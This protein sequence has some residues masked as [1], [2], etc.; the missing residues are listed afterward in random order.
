MN[1][2]QSKLEDRTL[3]ACFAGDHKYQLRLVRADGRKHLNLVRWTMYLICIPVLFSS[4]GSFCSQHVLVSLM[5][6]GIKQT[7][8]FRFRVF[9]MHKYYLCEFTWS[10]MST[11]TDWP[12]SSHTLFTS[13]IWAGNTNLQLLCKTFKRV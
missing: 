11:N 9:S 2:S 4:I 12:H 3:I 8:I 1:N 5:M 10:E 13:N 7:S 6:K